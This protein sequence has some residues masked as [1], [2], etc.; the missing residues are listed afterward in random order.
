MIRSHSRFPLWCFLIALY[1]GAG[2]V[3]AGQ[4]QPALVPP[5]GFSKLAGAV[6]VGATSAPEFG[7]GY[8]LAEWS[9]LFRRGHGTFI[10]LLSQKSF[11]LGLGHRFTDY[12]TAS[13]EVVSFTIGPSFVMAYNGAGLRSGRLCLF[14]AVSFHVEHPP[15]GA[16]V[17]TGP[18]KLTTNGS[19]PGSPAARKELN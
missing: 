3:A 17:A 10:G 4:T 12:V 7:V 1:A 8:P 14:A 11:G 15:P 13:H 18:L 19:A 16:K 5:S 6:I 2:G 9:S